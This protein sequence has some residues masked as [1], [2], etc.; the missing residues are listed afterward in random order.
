MGWLREIELPFEMT[1]LWLCVWRAVSLKSV[2]VSLAL[3]KTLKFS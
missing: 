2:R 1:V 3:S